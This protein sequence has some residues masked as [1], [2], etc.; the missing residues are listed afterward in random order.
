M[1]SQPNIFLQDFT[2]AIASLLP[3]PPPIYC[4]TSFTPPAP[5]IAGK[6]RSF[7]IGAVPFAPPPSLTP[8]KSESY[9]AD[10]QPRCPPFPSYPLL[11]GKGRRFMAARVRELSAAYPSTSMLVS[12]LVPMI[13]T[14]AS[15]RIAYLQRKAGEQINNTECFH[16]MTK[17]IHY[18]SNLKAQKSTVLA[19]HFS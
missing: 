3:A 1:V 7:M 9:A 18:M 15:T 10:T 6:G 12:W 2:S 19:Q 4:P 17:L 13:T 11:T 16:N 5:S 14:P 8:N